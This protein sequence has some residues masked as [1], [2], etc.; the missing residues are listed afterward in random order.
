VRPKLKNA[1]WQRAGVDLH[2][3]A[4]SVHIVLADEDGQIGWLLELLLEGTRSPAELAA[5]VAARSPSVEDAEVDAA[6][7]ALDE[8]GLLID[9]DADVLIPAQDGRFES[10]LGF[11]TPFAS[12][13]RSAAS[14]QRAVLDAHVVFLGAGGL[15]CAVLPALAGTGIRRM[16]LVDCDVVELKNL[17]TQYLYR[18][19]DIGRSK[20]ERAAAWVRDFSSLQLRVR[21]ER[22]R[23]AEDGAEL[24]AG[25]DLLICGIDT[26]DDADLIVNEACVR[27][28]VPFVYGGVMAREVIYGSVDPGRSACLMCARAAEGDRD[29]L[30]A[31]L[32]ARLGPPNRAVGPLVSMLGGLVATEALRY[33]TR[34]AEP[35]AAGCTRRIDFVTGDER[36]LRWERAPD[37]PACAPEPAAAVAPA[38]AVA[39]SSRPA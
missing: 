8:L 27:A 31:G 11:F 9:A 19:R 22:I 35:I 2:L 39:A 24:L 29:P 34:F 16:T 36:L 4:D 20:V 17:S 14:F 1:V 33:L 28:G 5:A 26:P 7:R 3:V 38:E 18:R 15:G 12:L 10:N 13:E 21:D 23:R 37:C 30:I 25:A 32:A 6:I